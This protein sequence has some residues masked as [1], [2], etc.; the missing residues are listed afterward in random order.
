LLIIFDLDDTLFF[1]LPDDYTDDDVNN[2][3]PYP[4]V[5]E[6][7]QRTDYKKVLVSKGTQEFQYRKLNSLGISELFDRIIICST[8]EE[9]RDALQEILRSYPEDNIWV[10]GDRRDSEIRYGNELG[11]KTVLLRSGKYKDLE[12]KDILEMPDYEIKEFKEFLK[13]I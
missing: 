13:L 11:F 2:I 7:L 3:K 1:R 8:G 10:I 6:L 4:G 5:L 12:A 9:K